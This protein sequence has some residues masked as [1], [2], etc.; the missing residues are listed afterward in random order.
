MLT[1]TA[2][3]RSALMTSVPAGSVTL[4]PTGPLG[5]LRQRTLEVTI[6]SM[7]ELMFDKDVAHAVENFRV[8]AGWA[9]GEHHAAP[10]MDGD[11]YKWL[12]SAVVA[13]PEAPH[14]AERVAAA[15][16]AIAA[17][18]QPDGYVHT[19][20]TIGARRDSSIAPL[21]DRLNFETYNL[22]HLITLGCLHRRL[23]GEDTYFAVALRAADYLLQ[24]VQEQPE[25]VGDCNICP[26]H[27]MAVIELYRSTRDERYLTL[28]RRL[29]D[30]HGGKGLDGGDDNQDVYPVQ[31]QPIASGHAVRANYLFA[32]MTDYALET[33]DEDFRAAVV[34]L[35][36]DVVA[37]KLYLTGGCGALYDGASPDAAQDY[38][39]VSKTHQAYGRPYE[40]P[41]TTAYNE[42]CATLGFVLWSWRML[43]L[44][45]ESRFADEIERVL[46]NSLPAMVDAEG[47]A[48]F[49][50]NPLRQVRDLPFQMRRAGDPEGTAPPPSDARLRQEYMTNCFCCP[51][52]IARV[53]AELPYYVYSQDPQ[54]LW[55][56]QFL[57]GTARLELA[58]QEVE[59]TQTTDYPGEG[60]V[61]IRVRAQRPVRAAVRIRRPGW[62]PQTQVHVQG[63]PVTA[64]ENG[65]VVIERT[66]SDE[67]IV[68][69]IPL[70]PRVMVAHHFV[71]EATNQAAVV[72]GPVVYCL[73][74]ADL[75][76]GVG[77]ESVHL[78]FPAEWQ[79]EAG[80]GLFADQVLL[81]TRAVTLPPV[82]PHG[83][84][85]GE[86]VEAPGTEIDLLLVPYAHWANRGPGEMT[87]WLPLLR[88][89]RESGGDV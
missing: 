6:P 60:Q 52:N 8:A 22:G 42:S 35:W 25:A 74:S 48:Y 71:E 75:P 85:Y 59:I 45:G 62:A 87:V 3:S 21:Q 61:R 13:Q 2:T 69:D 68:V 36:E 37:H 28:A 86:L 70:R 80:T 27:Y 34:R 18:Q 72:R 55:V 44:T 39:S 88:S 9:E 65:Y 83:A 23:T 82:V 40:L 67:E 41:H 64:V 78:P 16:E 5:R 29:L 17:A 26:S 31:D 14:L 32:G 43:L 66:W 1:D 89:A 38:S 81:R 58:G 63:E 56:H 7:G 33:G 24:A 50:T 84:L 11:L 15:L 4:A 30:L 51:P 20:T 57:P 79:T 46:F 54:S 73:E 49:Y 10:F 76:E 47:L 53:I 77:I 12:E 19:K